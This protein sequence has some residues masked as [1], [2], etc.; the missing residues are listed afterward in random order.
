MQ[1]ARDNLLARLRAD[2][3]DDAV[4][5]A[6]EAVPREEFVT[7]VTGPIVYEDAPLP[8][9]EGQT[10][11]QPYVVALMVSALELRRTDRVL[12]VGTGTGYQAAILAELARDV[13][14]VERIPSLAASARARLKRLGY[15]N[16][17]VE[18]AESELGWVRGAPYDAI[19]VAA[20]APKLP[21]TLVDQLADR[22]R[23]VVPVGS[24]EVQELIKL[25]RTGDGYVTRS[26]GA[27]G[28][29]VRT[30]HRRERMAEADTATLC[31]E[32]G[33]VVDLEDWATP[34]CL[35]RFLRP[36]NVREGCFCAWCCVLL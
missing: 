36:T 34:V 18:A 10:I 14:S 20:A 2:V 33:V 6:I 23:L 29:P 3:R 24:L 27:W 15:D 11:S 4:I 7:E 1:Q 32:S 16:V 19:V 31:L 30:S 26:L 12:E 28:G 21:R 17:D 25:T 35:R 5:R 8:I 22:G 13:V 9:G